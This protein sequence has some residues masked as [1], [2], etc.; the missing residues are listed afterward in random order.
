MNSQI[1]Q[2]AMGNDFYETVVK[3]IK[4]IKISYGKVKIM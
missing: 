2:N 3:Y 1:H 4:L